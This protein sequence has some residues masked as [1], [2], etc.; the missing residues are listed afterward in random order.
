MKFKV[1]ENLPVEMTEL[2]ERVGY[3]ATTVMEQGLSGSSDR[4]LASICLGEGRVMV[5]LDLDFADIRSYPPD[6]YA[7]IIVFRLLKQNKA[8]VLEVARRWLPL[9]KTE[10]LTGRLWIVDEDRVRIR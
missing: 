5:T 9:V 10:R 3:D 7:G 2:L 4:N 1:D 8:H 6:E